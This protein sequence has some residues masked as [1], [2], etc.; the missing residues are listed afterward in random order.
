MASAFDRQ[1]LTLAQ[2]FGQVRWTLLLLLTGIAGIGAAMLYSAANASFEPWA[3]RHIARFVI[4]VGIMLA[5]AMTDI[6][7]WLRHAYGIYLATLALLAAVEVMGSVGMGAQ[8]WIDLGI[9][10]LQPSEL[11]KIA[12]VLALARYFHGVNVE[13]IGRVTVL[14][15]PLA[16]IAAPAALVLRQPDLGTALMLLL[17]GGL[18]LF[19]AGVRLW[20]FALLAAGAMI[21]APIAW[22]SLH[23]YQRTRILTFLAPETDPLGAGYHIIQ[24]KIA[25][26]SGG[27]F[28]KGYLQGTQS[29]LNFLPEKQ[30][31]FI[32]TMLAEEFGLVGGVVLIGIY[33]LIL[34]YGF[35]I[36]FSSRHHFGRL[37]AIGVNITLFLYLFINVAM[38]MGLI[39]VVGVPLPLVSYGGTAMLSLMFGFGLTMSVWVHRDVPVPRRGV[40]DGL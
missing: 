20:K 22:Q 28:G 23:D 25:L 27:V 26:G 36:A 35:A 7:F 16:L 39:P 24:S 5:V 31:D 15:I 18:M 38:V 17:G 6:R 11:M 34:A 30:T 13:H 9:I 1:Q 29:H 32:F 33:V 21:A 37:L 19:A 14:V 40:G 4:S 2:K 12:L 8:R 10:N 3:I